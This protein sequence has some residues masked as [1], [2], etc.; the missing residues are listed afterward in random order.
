LGEK[1]FRAHLFI[2]ILFAGLITQDCASLKPTD[3]GTK[4]K[5]ENITV[6]STNSQTQIDILE[7]EN[8]KMRDQNEILNQQINK[9][10]NQIHRIKNENNNDMAIV[11]HQY[12]LMNEQINRLQ[13]EKR[14]IRDENETDMTGIRDQNEILNQQINLLKEE[15]RRIRSEN[16]TEIAR[17]TDQNELLNQQINKIKEENK[18]I[19]DKNETLKA[20][21]S[22]QKR[23]LNQQISKLKNHKQIIEPQKEELSRSKIKIKVSCGD[24]NLASASKMAKRLRKMGYKTQL[25]D[26]A[27][28]LDFEL[29]TVYFSLK[30]ENEARRLSTALG[31]NTVLK[32]MHGPSEFDLIVVTGKNGFES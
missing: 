7:K 25:I 22:D 24:G 29:N 14:K 5:N 1:M 10:K 30:F 23:L 15:N 16:K 8:Q 4:E 19:R 3:V 28:Q 17:I 6:I 2:L 18:K 32:P 20:K 9:L 31:D 12:K 13:E 26:Y 27:P 21:M 11:K